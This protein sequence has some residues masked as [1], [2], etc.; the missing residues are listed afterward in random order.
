MKAWDCKITKL[1]FAQDNLK[2][3]EVLVIIG[4]V[5]FDIDPSCFMFIEHFLQD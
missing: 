5:G 2:Y 1:M 4:I 3:F